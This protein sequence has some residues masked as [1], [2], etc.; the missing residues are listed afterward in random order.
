MKMAIYR[1]GIVFEFQIHAIRRTPK[2]QR[3]TWRGTRG[4]M[5]ELEDRES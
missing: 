4:R 1:E 3:N 2:F 5:G